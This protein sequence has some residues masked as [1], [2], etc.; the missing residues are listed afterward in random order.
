MLWRLGL[1]IVMG[2]CVGCSFLTPGL[3]TR[4]AAAAVNRTSWDMDSNLLIDEDT[5]HN[6][7]V[8]MI[9]G[10]DIDASF[11]QEGNIYTVKGAT[12]VLWQKSEP[13]DVME[14]YTQL[15][16]QNARVAERMFGAIEKLTGLIAPLLLDSGPTGTQPGE[17]PSDIVVPP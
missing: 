15:A 6:R 3:D 12:Q 17:T 4:M 9:E 2:G 7:R 10:D 13:R 1:S 11:D 14:A 8:L 5:T 16:V